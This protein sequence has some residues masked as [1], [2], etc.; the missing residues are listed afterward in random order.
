M[1]CHY[2]PCC[3]HR[4]GTYHIPLS[5]PHKFHDLSG[6]NK[7][8]VSETQGLVSP[9]GDSVNLNIFNRYSLRYHGGIHNAR[10]FPPTW[11]EKFITATTTAS[12]RGCGVLEQKI[13][14]QNW[15][16]MSFPPPA[17]TKQL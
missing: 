17:S 15:V 12:P 13:V 2:F 8:T 3:N 11:M 4:A 9:V 1:I 5:G 6:V 16:Q 10:R 14:D 7:L